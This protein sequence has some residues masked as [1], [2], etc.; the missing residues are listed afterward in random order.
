V[1]DSGSASCHAQSGGQAAAQAQSSVR[2]AQT[3]RPAATAPLPAEQSAAV[4]EASPTPES[5]PL[6]FDAQPQPLTLPPAAGAGL[7][8][9]VHCS[10]ACDVHATLLVSGQ[11]VATYRETETEIPEPFSRIELKLPDSIADSSTSVPVVLKFAAMDAA[12]EVKRVRRELT[13][14]PG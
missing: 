6:E 5:V 8:V 7:P 1:L 14:S 3:S 13:L 10:R 9:D 11:T 2:T 4:L 12:G